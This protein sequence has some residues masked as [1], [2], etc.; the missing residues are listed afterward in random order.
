MLDALKDEADRLT[1]K[2]A[3]LQRQSAFPIAGPTPAETRKPEDKKVSKS[4]DGDQRV[5]DGE[6]W[7]QSYGLDAYAN[8]LSDLGI[9]NLHDCACLDYEDLCHSRLEGESIDKLW[10]LL[11]PIKRRYRAVTDGSTRFIAE[12]RL[13]DHASVLSSL[14]VEAVADIDVVETEDL[15]A[16][17]VPLDTVPGLWQRMETIRRNAAIGPAVSVEMGGSKTF[18]NSHRL[19]QWWSII[20][21]LG[22]ESREDLEDVHFTDL[23]AEGLDRGQ[24]IQLWVHLQNIRTS[25]WRVWS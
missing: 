12:H 24:A 14:G 23:L 2:V 3:H 13:E 6:H 10:K 4:Q 1:E 16:A 17:G 20:K 8:A 19:E 25:V 7:L 18:I 5:L 9:E 22:I 21:E 11:G 15:L